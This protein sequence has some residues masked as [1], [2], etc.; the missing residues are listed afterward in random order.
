[1]AVSFYHYSLKNRHIL[2][3]YPMDKFVSRYVTVEVDPMYNRWG[4]WAD[5]AMSWVTM[6]QDRSGFLLLRYEDMVENPERELAKVASL[7]NLMSLRKVVPS[8]GTQLSGS[9]AP[10]GEGATQSLDTNQPHPRGQTF[11]RT[12]GSGDWR[13]SLSS[14]AIAEIEEAWGP[15]M[16]TLGYAL[17]SSVPLHEVRR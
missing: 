10:P 5:H 3:G 9:D 16:Q 1:V 13:T 17:S 2:D 8:S 4:S 12:A 11:V 6:R 14:A 15:V 7:L